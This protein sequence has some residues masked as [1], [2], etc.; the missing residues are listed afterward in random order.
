VNTIFRETEI[1]KKIY[2]EGGVLLVD[3]VLEVLLDLQHVELHSLRQ[4]GRSNNHSNLPAIQ[5]CGTV[6]N[7]CD[8]G[9][10]FRKVLVPVPAQDLL[11]N[12]Y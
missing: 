8:S 1:E 5:C 6:M 4:P 11:L 9:F 3:V 7:Y 12:I 10:D 2:R